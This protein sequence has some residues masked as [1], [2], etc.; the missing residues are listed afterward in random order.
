[1]P[2]MRHLLSV[3]LHHALAMSHSTKG[4]S[5]PTRKH[6]TEPSARRSVCRGNTFSSQRATDLLLK[7]PRAAAASQG[8]M[9]CMGFFGRGGVGLDGKLLLDFA[10]NEV[11]RDGCWGRWNGPTWHGASG[12][13]G[14]GKFNDG[15]GVV[16]DFECRAPL[17]FSMI[18]E[19]RVTQPSGMR[20]V[21]LVQA[22]VTAGLSGE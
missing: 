19:R 15:C 17:T 8:C 2:L 5:L 12:S 10:Y 9:N 1:M 20:V 7:R 3:H 16:R 22:E 4:A 21:N 11:R 13:G 14:K 18:F 6:L